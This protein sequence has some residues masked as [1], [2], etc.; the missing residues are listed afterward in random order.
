M[1]HTTIRYEV[2]D[3]VATITLDRP[4]ARNGYT[5]TM[6]DELR[7]ALDD[8]DRDD[9]VRVVVLTG[10]GRDFCVGAD[11]SD[12]GGLGSASASS[13]VSA[14]PTDWSEPAGRV[15]TRMYAMNKPV[16]AALNGAA[17]GGGLTITLAADFR[18]GATDS[19][20]GF[21]F[22]RR[23]IAAEGCSHWLLP[24]LVGQARATDWM[25]TGR[26]FGSEEALAAGL[27][28]SVHEPAALLDAAYTLAADMVANTA[29]VSVALSRRLMFEAH[30]MT[31][32][33][34]H[35]LESRLVMHTMLGPDVVEGVTSFLQR[36][37][38]RFTG[39]VGKDLP[40][41]LP[42]A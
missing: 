25:L 8:A 3:W 36:R 39:S 20:F 30:T 16:I 12:G 1:T 13:E 15:S 19:K 5:V 4:Q 24:R 14:L 17:A 23:G 7:A 38:P 32:D 26:V 22:T 40:D 29:P 41:F 35:R 28:H 11:L 9:D 37:P 34:V 21:V 10:A 33:E 31:L 18:L 6:A 27:L 2:H 42:W